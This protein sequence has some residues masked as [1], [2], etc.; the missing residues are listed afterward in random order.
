[1]LQWRSLR[2]P[3]PQCRSSATNWIHLVAVLGRRRL[4]LVRLLLLLLLLL[5]HLVVAVLRRRRRRL[6]R[7]VVQMVGAAWGQHG[8]NGHTP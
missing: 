2:G 4:V 3:L 8:Q 5:V 1:M 6:V 7:L